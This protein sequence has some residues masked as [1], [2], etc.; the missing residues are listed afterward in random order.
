MQLPHRTSIPSCEKHDEVIATQ[1][2]VAPIV[3]IH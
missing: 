1:D 3:D 2:D